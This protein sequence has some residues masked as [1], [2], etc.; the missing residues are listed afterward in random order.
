MS[1]STTSGGISFTGLLTI[2][3]VA[4]KLWGK[5][6]WSWIWVFSPLWIGVGLV[7]SIFLGLLVIGGA[8][9]GV[10]SILE[11]LGNI[12]KRFRRNRKEKAKADILRTIHNV[13]RLPKKW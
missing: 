2:V 5:I 4:A 8:L 11:T 10:G 3:F 7:V 13:E 12:P 9:Y 6:T 1:N